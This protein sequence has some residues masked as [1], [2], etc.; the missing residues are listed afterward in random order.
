MVRDGM[1]RLADRPL[2]V[3][4]VEDNEDIRR[5]FDAL[6][7]LTVGAETEVLLAS[8]G[9]EGVE[10]ALKERP[11]VIFMDEELP[12]MDGLE[13]TRRL[14]AQSSLRDVP[15]IMISAHLNREERRQRAKE[16]GV[17][18]LIDKPFEAQDLEDALRRVLGE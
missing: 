18:L 11:D 9:E 6:I 16:A 10:L 2:K 15:V 5:V 12:L 17:T 3:L 1:V 13:A 14:R 8:D 4:Y 7:R